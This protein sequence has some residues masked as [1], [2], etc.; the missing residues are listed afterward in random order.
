MRG[1]GFAFLLLTVVAVQAWGSRI[2]VTTTAD[3]IDSIGGCSLKE[4][5]YSAVLHTSSD[6]IHGMAIAGY[7]DFAQPKFITTECVPGDGVDDTIVLPTQG[8]PLSKITDDADN[9]MGPTATPMIST[10]ITIEGNG[11][12]LD[13]EGPAM[14]LFAVGP[15]GH[16]TLKFVSVYRFAVFGGNGGPGAGGGMGAGGAIYVNNGTLVIESCTFARNQVRGG[17]GGSGNET[18][19][20]GSGG[21]GLSGS[22]FHGDVFDGTLIP[23]GGGGARGNGFADVGG[24]TLSTNTRGFNCGG[25][26]ETDGLCPGGGGAGGGFNGAYG[27]GGGGGAGGFQ[28]LGSSDGGRG[29]FGGGGGSSERTRA[30][31]GAS[32]GD[33]GFGGGAGAGEIGRISGGGSGHAGLNGGAASEFSG[34][35]GAALGGAIFNDEGHVTVQNSTFTSNSVNRG[36][37]GADPDNPGGNGADLGAAIYSFHGTMIIRNSTISYNASTGP[38]GG[39]V[40]DNRD[41]PCDDDA[42]LGG[43]FGSLTLENTIIA[44]NGGDLSSP[45]ECSVL[46]GVRAPLLAG[47][48]NLIMQNDTD[49]SACPGL[50]GQDDP[51]LGDLRDNLGLTPTMAIPHGSPAWGAADGGLD[52]DQRGQKRPSK[53]G[54]GFDIGAFELCEPGN[55]VLLCVIPKFTEGN[56]RKLIVDSTTGGTTTP[57]PGTY[58]EAPSS[59]VLLTATANPGY[60]FK[61]WDGEVANDPTNPSNAVIM[62]RD[63]KEVGA[64]FQLHDFSLTPNPTSLTIPLGGSGSSTIA[65]SSLG[66]FGDKVNVSLSAAPAGVNASVNPSL[67]TPFPG[68]PPVTSSLSFT[69]GSSVTPQTFM[70]TVTGTTTG[71][72]G[73]L[74]HSAQINVTVVATAAAVVNVINQDQV[75]GCVDNSGV[76]QSL[77][78]KINAYTKLSSGG[79]TQGA[80]NTLT[81]FQYEV[82]AQTG[83]H[84]TTTCTDPVGGNRFY[85]GQTLITDAQSLQAALGTQVK[86]NPIVGS[87]LNSSNG[88]ISGA[89]VNL[90]SSSKT[91]I[92]TTTTDA[93][94]FYY[95]TGTSG[96]T[97]GLTYVVNI[98]LP[99]GYKSSKPASQTFTW[100]AGPVKLGNFVLN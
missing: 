63:V 42:C 69:A 8:F 18:D 7:T 67:V 94:G 93:V 84:I 71:I 53:D 77:I 78:A 92:A 28:Q 5:V 9:F 45:K 76:G 24:G 10:K 1:L 70:E 14:R 73:S 98:T 37:G 100:S 52:F 17:R 83:Q 66:D 95:F 4:A 43:L 11:A 34:G 74:T 81:A 3:K 75:L 12:A 88:G 56:P 91:V 38:L 65:T 48:G 25:L 6:G 31:F 20:A 51:Q 36:D 21:G 50:V 72:G 59:V 58:E 23:G 87:V 33:G 26:N 68:K 54:H 35:G 40:F 85:T 86:A 22:G 60:Y 57:L 82:Q 39:L 49:A 32:G 29:G 96:L 55:D 13:L 30:L 89:T 64:F 47:S 41:L 80:T 97:P 15:T 16:L 99:K 19:Q 2:Y 44:H 90:L 27:G 62:D 79:Q 46:S 61:F